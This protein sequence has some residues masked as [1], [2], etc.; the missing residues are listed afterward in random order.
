MTDET[1]IKIF[2]ESEATTQKSIGSPEPAQLWIRSNLKNQLTNKIKA[3]VITPT[4][5]TAN[6]I[7]FCKSNR[8]ANR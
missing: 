7:K 1:K 5:Y 4:F 3:F 2:L 6:N 8:R